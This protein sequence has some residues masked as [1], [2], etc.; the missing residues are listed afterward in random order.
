MAPPSSLQSAFQIFAACASLAHPAIKH[1]GTPG[2]AARRDLDFVV[3]DWKLFEE[4]EKDPDEICGLI[5]E[6]IKK[7]VKDLLQ[8]FKRPAKR[9]ASGSVKK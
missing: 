2:Q 7:D 1:A 8:E 5:P 9:T 3:K 4:G 6:S